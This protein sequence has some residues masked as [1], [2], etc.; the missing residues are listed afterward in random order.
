MYRMFDMTS[1]FLVF[2]CRLGVKVTQSHLQ[3][4]RV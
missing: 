4:G 3:Q 1:C 2:L